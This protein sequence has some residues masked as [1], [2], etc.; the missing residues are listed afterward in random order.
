MRRD[1]DTFTEWQPEQ[2]L[3][4]SSRPGPGGK[5]DGAVV[6]VEAAL[7]V[8]VEDAVLGGVASPGMWPSRMD[9]TGVDPFRE[10][11]TT[12]SLNSGAP[13]R[14]PPVATTATY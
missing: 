4:M 1:A 2:T 6:F 9:E 5:G 14:P 12:T 7:Y 10:Y 8:S 11:A 13:I 3:N